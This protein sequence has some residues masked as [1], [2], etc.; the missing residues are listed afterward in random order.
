MTSRLTEAVD[1]VR[2]TFALWRHADDPSGLSA[3][4]QT[5]ALYR[6][7]QAQR[8]E[9]EEHAEHASQVASDN[10][11]A[12]AM[13]AAQVTR[14]YLA[15]MRNELDVAARW[16]AEAAEI[17]A[18]NRSE[19]LALRSRL[20]ASC[21]QLG[22]SDERA[23]ADLVEHIE[24]ARSLG[25]DELASTGYSQLA[26][27]DV[28]QRRLRSAELVLEQGLPFAKER[29]I[30]I[31]QH[32]QMSVR[33]R[34]RFLE[35][36]WKAALEDAED[37][38]EDDGMP[39]AGVWPHLVTALVGLRSGEAARDANAHLE[40]AWSLA[41]SIVEPLRTLPVLSALAERM[42]LTG[43]ENR[44]VVDEAPHAL[45]RVEDMPGAQ[46]AVADLSAWLRRLGLRDEVTA[47]PAVAGGRR[48]ADPFAAAM[49]LSDSGDPDDGLEAVERL[50]ALGA[51]A[52][53]DRL[54]VW[55]RRTAG[56][57][58]SARPRTTT[59]AN[60]GGLTNRQ[61][62][63]ARLVSR[64]LTNAEIAARL[65]ISPKTTDHHVSAVLTKLGLASRRAVVVRADE[66]GL[67]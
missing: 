29:D 4:Y 26:S 27:L 64:G 25:L 56:V 31:C 52:T 14:A 49:A 55:W 35:G 10:G 38:L 23:R 12:V 9:A 43:Q 24:A 28:E 42:W 11:V 13:G 58:V 41:E 1:S 17:A 32:W 36:R 5:C 6:Y 59:R 48:D 20:I 54:R 16:C 67:G 34:L 19:S 30:P 63:V 45:R 40:Q 51:F 47:P 66:L 33:S 15:Y 44:R 22:R 57:H 65:Y 18:E 62:D 8:R 61:L 2:A 39:L 46:W 21:T 53:A 50:D 3:A 37:V 60:P 7:Y